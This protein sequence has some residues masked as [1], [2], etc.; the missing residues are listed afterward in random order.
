MSVHFR[1]LIACFAAFSFVCLVLAFSSQDQKAIDPPET[2]SVRVSVVDQLNRFVIGL[3]QEHFRIYE[4]KVQQEIIHFAQQASPVSAGIVFDVG[5]GMK[6]RKDY[7]LAESAVLRF[8]KSGNTDD[9]NFLVTFNPDAKRIQIFI[10]P[11]EAAEAGRVIKE[12][13]GQTALYDS[14]YMA[15]DHINRT[16]YKNKLL[17]LITDGEDYRSRHKPSEIREFVKESDVQIYAIG[18]EGPMGPGQNE[19]QRIVGIAGGRI[20]FP[21]NFSELGSSIEMIRS[22]FRSQYLLSYSPT[23]KN[24]DGKWRKIT[25]KV[26]LVPK[27]PNLTIRARAGRYAPKN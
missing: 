5:A 19:R 21:N 14:I 24:R 2:V 8:L 6:K 18:R 13:G 15:L 11:A 9:E 23:N 26:D 25:V 20:Y 7:E 3:Q 1:L 12:P 22:E 17:I 4:D 10:G 27:L 16:K